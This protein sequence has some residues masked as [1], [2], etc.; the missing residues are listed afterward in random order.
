MQIHSNEESGWEVLHVGGVGVVAQGALRRTFV[1]PRVQ[2]T[3][4]IREAP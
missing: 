4:K 1:M 3:I 2:T